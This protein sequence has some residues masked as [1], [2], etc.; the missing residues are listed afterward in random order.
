VT[1]RAL[2][3]EQRGCVRWLFLSRPAQ[4]NALN[5]ELTE[6]LAEQVEEIAVDEETTVVVVAGD[7]PSFSAGGDFQQFLALKD[8]QSVRAF[9]TRLSD[10]ITRI[11]R[12]SK[13]WIAALHGHAI[14]GGLEIALACDVVVAAEGTVIGDG[15]VN[16][17]LLPGAG[18][19]VRLERAVG[20][21]VARW[22]HLSGQPMVAE[23]LRPTGWLHD[24][25][26]G[27]Q[28]LTQVEAIA[29]QLAARD[30]FAQ[31]GTDALKTELDAFESNWRTND[32]ADALADFFARTTSIEPE[33]RR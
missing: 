4:R 32:V 17:K 28:L 20:K 7:G 24:V 18:S 13:P 21:S 6:A 27:G 2:R 9:L 1:S 23:A 15:H 29:T 8:A 11:E 31:Q 22:M 30:A 12:S 14:A 5:I 19:S 3:V 10:V 25:V 16:N 26:P 33:P